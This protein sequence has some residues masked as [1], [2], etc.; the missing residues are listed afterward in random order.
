MCSIEN[1]ITGNDFTASLKAI[2]PSVLEGSLTGIFV[3]SYLQSVT[4]RLSL[5]METVWQRPL[6]SHGPTA[7]MSW[8]GRYKGNDW[9]GSL[10]VLSQGGLQAS[11]WR[12]LMDKVE[13]GVDLSLQAGAMSENPLMGGSAPEGQATI[14]AKYDFRQS[15]FRAQINSAG[16]VACLLEKR[17]APTVQLTFSGEIDHPKVRHIKSTPPSSIVTDCLQNNAKVGLAV[18][19]ESA[20]DEVMEQQEQAG[21]DAPAVPF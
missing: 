5:G 10:Q 9:I 8:A 19:L 21:V 7:L 3:A 13:A 4:P 20:T 17:V 2:N 15:S 12:R 14:G 18:T 6:A 11:Y 16:R 1:D